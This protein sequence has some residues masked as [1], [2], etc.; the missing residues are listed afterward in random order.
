MIYE[1]NINHA[2]SFSSLLNFEAGDAYYGSIQDGDL[3]FSKRLRI[4]DWEVATPQ[5]KVKA[6]YEATSIIEN[7][8]FRGCKAVSTQR[9]QFPRGSDTV[10]P[11]A[12]NNAAYEIAILLLGGLDP[13]IES[14]NANVKQFKFGQITTEYSDSKSTPPHVSAGI[15]S[16][17]AWRLLYPFIRQNTEVDLVRV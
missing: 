1:Y 12:I 13:E 11:E 3:Y 10:V 14:Q 2:L 6:L 7:L 5:D 15:F 4:D 16:A 9:L 17:K 8:N